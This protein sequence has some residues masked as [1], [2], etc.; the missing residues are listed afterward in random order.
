[1]KVLHT[2]PGVTAPSSAPG[3]GPLR[4]AQLILGL[5]TGLL[6]KVASV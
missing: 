6:H 3:T 1:M 4:P 2:W 5:S